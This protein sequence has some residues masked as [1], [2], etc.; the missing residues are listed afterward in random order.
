MALFRFFLGNSSQVPRDAEHVISQSERIRADRPY[1]L[2]C[3]QD[4]TTPLTERSRNNSPASISLAAWASTLTSALVTLRRLAGATENEFL[5]IGSKMQGVHQRAATLSQ[6]AQNLVEVASGEGIQTLIEQLRQILS[7][8]ETYLEETQYQNLNYC[9]AFTTVESQLGKIA[10]P[11]EGFKKMSKELYI[12]EVLIKIESAHV[13]SIGGEFLNL[14]LDINKLTQQIKDKSNTI[15]DNQSLLSSIISKNIKVASAALSTQETMVHLTHGDTITSIAELESVNQRFFILGSTV[16]ATATENSNHISQVVQSM[17]FHDIFR[18]QVEHVTEALEG[19]LPSLEKSNRDTA[20]P[21]DGTIEDVIRRVGDVCELQEAQLQFASGELYAAVASIIANLTDISSQ[22]KLMAQEIFSHS[23]ISNNISGRSFIDDVRYHMA[24]ITELLTSCAETN[25]NLA[26]IM[27]E[28]TDTVDEIT[29][30]VS[31]IEDIG[32]DINIIA[33]NARIKAAGAG[34]KGASLCVL[35]EEI[36]FLSRGD[37][38]RTDTIT[39][40]LTA[41]HATTRTLYADAK[42]CEANLAAKLIEMKAA[43][44][45]ILTILGN[46]GRELLAL[47]AQIHNQVDA[48]VR[49][50]EA[51]N[52]SIDVHERTKAMADEVLN[53]LRQ[54]CDK[55]R[56]LYPAS[57]AFKEDLRLM[58]SRYTMESERRIHEDIAR[59]HGVLTENIHAQATSLLTSDSEFGDNVDLF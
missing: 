14:A 51:I 25:S 20:T 32:N 34:Q 6:T 5:Q 41:I 53:T 13:G 58:A 26:V 42:H 22:Q 38:H 9:T 23:G 29:G 21:G 24:S 12:L 52:R 10:D 3:R 44:N 47:L 11:L 1:R 33:L 54:I 18:Q 49:E 55:S 30:Y 28:V 2:D 37:A 56:E 17:Q 45:N 35:A 48:L 39:A 57:D 7:E 4:G 15:Q 31:D 8:M 40:S 19:L 16:S 36:G 27:K 43:L 59:K 46:M 50:I